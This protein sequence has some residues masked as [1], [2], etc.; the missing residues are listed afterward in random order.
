MAIRYSIKPN[1]HHPLTILREHLHSLKKQYRQRP[2][3]ELQTF[4][5]FFDKKRPDYST[6]ACTLPKCRHEVIEYLLERGKEKFKAEWEGRYGWPFDDCNDDRTFA[7]RINQEREK[8]SFL[9]ARAELLRL[10]EALA[11]GAPTVDSGPEHGVTTAELEEALE[12][13]RY[14]WDEEHQ[15]PVWRA[16]VILEMFLPAHEMAVK[17]GEPA[18][19]NCLVI[20][21]ERHKIYTL[22]EFHKL[23][24]DDQKAI[25][26]YMARRIKETVDAGF[27][28]VIAGT[29]GKL[30]DR[31]LHPNAI[32]CT[33][34]PETATL[35][36][37]AARQKTQ[38]A[39]SNEQ[40]VPVCNP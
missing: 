35:R 38:P 36:E 3:A 5:E 16:G 34:V 12:I 31:R 14:T 27:G 20:S 29:G 8:N 19:F 21:D 33:S 9:L 1:P 23:E 39:E 32:P 6:V 4:M 13:N 18:P 10:R 2:T 40:P 22:E 26:T 15:K 24:D 28:G 30:V 25:R 17:L 11:A 37:L 7:A